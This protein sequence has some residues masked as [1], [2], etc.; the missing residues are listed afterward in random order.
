MPW[1]IFE[2]IVLSCQNH[3]DFKIHNQ[4]KTGD[5]VLQNLQVTAQAWQATH[6]PLDFLFLKKWLSMLKCKLLKV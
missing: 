1:H 4:I 5:K 2:A 3:L 6:S